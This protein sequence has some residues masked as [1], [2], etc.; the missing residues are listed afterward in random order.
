MK[1]IVTA[2][3]KGLLDGFLS[4]FTDRSGITKYKLDLTNEEKTLIS[5]GYPFSVQYCM[6]V[7]EYMFL[8]HRCVNVNRCFHVDPHP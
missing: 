1:A 8:Q 4:F 2:V 6:Y 7:Y 5:L 3:A